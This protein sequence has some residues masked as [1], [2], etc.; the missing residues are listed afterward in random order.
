MLRAVLSTLVSLFVGGALISAVQA[1][2]HRLYPLPG[3]LDMN[4]P[5]ALAAVI[6]QA[7]VG[8]LLMV[9][10]AYAVGCFAA[11]AVVTRLAPG[12]GLRLPLIIGGLFTGAGFMN[13]AAIPHPLWF[14]VLTTVTYVPMS[15]LGAKALGEG[16]GADR[17]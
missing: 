4:D 5:A 3:E 9:E 6:A 2:G 14:A 12:R 7:P 16:A 10:L 11:G 13:M 15:V 8:A 17:A 1:L